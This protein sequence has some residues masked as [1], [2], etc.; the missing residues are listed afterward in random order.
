MRPLLSSCPAERTLNLLQGRWKIFILHHLFAGEARHSE[1]RRSVES[2][3]GPVSQKMLTQELRTLERDGLLFRSVTP[4]KV[5]NV[6]YGLTNIGLELRPILESMV[7]W[8]YDYELN[9]TCSVTQPT[10]LLGDEMLK[11][12]RE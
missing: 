9:R 4:G 10:C 6:R 8:G 2:S 7:R 5:P 12:S 3:A 1:L 11:A